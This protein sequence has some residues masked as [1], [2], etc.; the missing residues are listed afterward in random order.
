VHKAVQEVQDGPEAQK[1]FASEGAEI[2]RTTP[3]EFGT[4]MAREM[5]KWE[6]V[7]KQG[8]IKAE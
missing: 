2:V 8:G 1:Q 3:A 7:V 6:R 4:F 5:A